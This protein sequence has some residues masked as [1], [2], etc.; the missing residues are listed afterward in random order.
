MSLAL[1]AF[2]AFLRPDHTV[3]GALLHLAE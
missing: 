2:A 3:I 1:R